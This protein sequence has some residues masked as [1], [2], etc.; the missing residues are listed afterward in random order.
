MTP[1]DSAQIQTSHFQTETPL[2]LKPFLSASSLKMRRQITARGE[3]PSSIIISLLNCTP[4]WVNTAQNAGSRLR[5][6]FQLKWLS[7]VDPLDTTRARD[8]EAMPALVPD[9]EVQVVV[10]HTPQVAFPG[11][12]T[13][14]EWAGLPLFIKALLTA[15]ATMADR[16]TIAQISL[17]SRF[18]WNQ[19]C[20]L[21]KQKPSRTH[22]T[23]SISH[24]PSTKATN[25]DGSHLVCRNT[26]LPRSKPNTLVGTYQV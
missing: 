16:T 1:Q 3:L 24:T 25:R 2:R 21:S 5:R 10:D 4:M 11:L 12:Q 18:H 17:L 23:T 8:E 20:R 6:E 9:P 22:P 15:V 7:E 26:H 19:S 14:W 13:T